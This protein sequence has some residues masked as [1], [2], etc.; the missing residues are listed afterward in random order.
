MEREK[1]RDSLYV[2][3]NNVTET[4]FPTIICNILSPKN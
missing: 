3:L 1:D 4:D 2:V